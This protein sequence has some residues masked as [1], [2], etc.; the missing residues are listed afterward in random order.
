V[1]AVH[2]WAEVHRVHHVEGLS[3][4]AIAAKLGM[5]RT[6]V[7]RLLGL[8]R[9]PRYQRAPVACKLDRFHDQIAAMLR[10]DPKVPATV[11]AERL[12]PHG[13]TGSLTILKDHLRQVRPVF[14][15]AASYQRTSYLPGELAQVD[16]WHSGLE[17][18]VGKGA[19]RQ[20]F[21]LVASLPYSAALRVVFTLACGVA[22]FCAAL[23]GCLQ[24]L[25]GLP[26]GIV[27]DN[28]TAIVASRRGGTVR[29]AEEVA[30]VYGAL[31]L[32]AVVLRPRFPQGKGQVERAI[33]YLETSFLPLRSAGDLVDLQSQADAW[34]T[35][36]AD[37][38]QVRRLG[39]RVAD[40][41]IV[42]RAALRR[43]PE[44][45][46]DVDR[47]LEVRASR[48]GFVRVAGVDDSVTPGRPPPWGAA[49][50]DRG[51]RG[52]RG[53][54]GR[55]ACSLLGAG[56]RG[57]GPSPR[58][59]AAPG[60]RGDR[61]LGGQ[62]RSSPSRR[63]WRLRPAGRGTVMTA[64]AELAHLTRALKAPRI[65]RVAGPLAERARAEGW[66]YERDLAA[67]LEEE[68][69]ARETSG[70]QLRVKAARLP[71]IKTLDDFD[72]TFQ[73]S[74]R[75]QVIAHLAQLDFL[76]EASN[77]VFLGPPGTP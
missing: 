16:W 48:D 45:W 11:I 66:P 1:Y 64:A 39:A 47:R 53:R 71:A 25:G 62:R 59:A 13:F 18:P 52:L 67:V 50:T 28:D 30:A 51:H 44:R 60:P 55:P 12:R 69:L 73:R 36:V 17:V 70:G 15:A 5:S 40:A 46:P 63:P 58:P 8:T 37:Q 33:G 49:V 31:G 72:F 54:R 3:K 21:G 4:Q 29:L 22:E 76:L 41:L 75:K 74:V 43:L 20:A 56:R 32:R 24:R 38:R 68:V 34:T 27:S 42:E 10:E 61:P 57:A 26:G 14:V 2:D 9:P 7:H 6:T 35:E 65:R 77:V 23:V 19:T